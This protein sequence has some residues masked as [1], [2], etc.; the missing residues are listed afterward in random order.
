MKLGR[1]AIAL[2]I[3]TGAGLLAYVLTNVR[4]FEPSIGQVEYKTIDYRMRSSR[5]VNADSTDVRLVLFDSSFVASW[6][7]LSPFPRAALASLIDAA[8]QAGAKAIG[9]DVYLDRRYE[10]LNALDSGDV[11]LR[12]AMQRAGNVVLVAPTVL[13]TVSGKRMLRPPDPYFA[14]VAA[15]I[16]SADTPTPYEIQRDG[17]LAVRTANAGMVPS[18]ALALYARSRGLDVDE[19][20]KRADRTG[21]F[22]IPSLPAEYARNKNDA[23]IVTFPILFEG[24]PSATDRDDGAF[25]AVS[26]FAVAQLAGIPGAAQMMLDVKDK[27]VLMGSGFHDSERYRSP[28]YDATRKSGELFGWTYGVEIHAN[29]LQNLLSGHFVKPLNA[30]LKFLLLV[31]IA[32][33]VSIFTFARGTKWGAF[34]AVALSMVSGFIAF[35]VFQRSA[36][37]VPIVGPTLASLFAFLGSTSYVSIVEG[38]EKRMIKGAFGK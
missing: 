29:A 6:P 2:L 24:P 19:M 18:F 20:L 31:A 10:T 13:D 17:V 37:V 32:I 14:D 27:V 7:Y 35:Y 21:R 25:K 4:F 12:S 16:S 34:G 11:K 15:G 9:V 38:A 36:L 5:T 28:F 30:V 8:A 1:Y 23:T 3:A 22:D 33:A 26:A